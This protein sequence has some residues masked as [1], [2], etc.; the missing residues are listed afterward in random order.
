MD[1]KEDGA[2]AKYKDLIVALPFVA[3]ALAMAWQVGRFFSL[4]GFFLFTITEHLTAAVYALPIA[5]LA[6]IIAVPVG[7]TVNF[8]K[9]NWVHVVGAIVVVG[10]TAWLGYIVYHSI[11]LYSLAVTTTVLLLLRP[12]VGNAVGFLAFGTAALFLALTVGIDYTRTEVAQTNES[13]ALG[14]ATKILTKSGTIP[15][16]VI[17]MGERGALIYRPDTETF[18]FRGS[19]DVQLIEWPK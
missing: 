15:G 7:Y 5:V 6:L 17:M 14:R 16:R 10:L 1:R 4:D 9:R 2:I 12:S 19:G 11:F 8:E 18:E 13:F 3:S